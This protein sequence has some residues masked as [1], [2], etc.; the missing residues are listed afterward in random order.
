MMMQRCNRRA[1]RHHE[2]YCAGALAMTLLLLTLAVGSSPAAAAA[3]SW[4]LT[5]HDDFDTLD[6]AK[7]TVAGGG[8]HGADELQLYT[9]DAV[10]VED[11]K[12]IITT[13]WD[14]MD[15]MPA[16]STAKLPGPSD[17]HGWCLNARP[18]PAGGGPGPPGTQRLNFTS[19]WLDTELRFAQRFGRFSV[20]AKLPDVQA[21]NIWP[22]HWLVPDQSTPDC[23]VGKK[24]CACCW[25]VGGEIDIMES[26]GN[27][28]PGKPS[29]GNVFA[30]YHWANQSGHDL[31]CGGSTPEKRCA[32]YEF[33]GKYPK[34]GSAS[35]FS[36][37][38]HVYSIDWNESS[39]IWSV[40]GEQVRLQLIA[41]PLWSCWS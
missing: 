30:T 7:W 36:D 33:N 18:A 4:N 8:V 32:P 41:H 5:F 10:A 1:S 38:F 39:I 26:Y 2:R 24:D 25:P 20:R 22:A 40:D 6:P 11:G 21:A 3:G 29:R 35:D 16:N 19:G 37:G 27:S 13:S 9:R 15:C 14:P 17:G 31:H 23:K 12:L 28:T 34:D